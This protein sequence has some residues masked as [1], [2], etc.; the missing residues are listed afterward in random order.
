MFLCLFLSWIRNPECPT[1]CAITKE[2][3]EISSRG[4]ELTRTSPAFPNQISE[5]QFFFKKCWQGEVD[6]VAASILQHAELAALA[7]GSAT[8]SSACAVI[9]RKEPAGAELELQHLQ[10]PAP[11]CVR[12]HPRNDS[13]GFGRKSLQ[14]F[15]WCWQVVYSAG[16]VNNLFFYRRQSSTINKSAVIKQWASGN[17]IFSQN[18]SQSC[19]CTSNSRF[20]RFCRIL[21]TQVTQTFLHDS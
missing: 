15:L 2:T 8:P 18:I 17:D 5:D 7:S 16:M 11:I 13:T 14:P 9:Q 6:A 10:R 4:A 1:F 20:S 12:V 19:E 21:H 3:D